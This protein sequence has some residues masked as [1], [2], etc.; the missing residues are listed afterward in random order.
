MGGVQTVELLVLQERRHRRMV[1]LLQLPFAGRGEGNPG[2]GE[3]LDDVVR[4]IRA[5][6]CTRPEG[7]G[8]LI[9]QLHH[10]ARLQPARIALAQQPVEQRAVH[11]RPPGHPGPPHLR[12]DQHARGLRGQQ[13]PH[14]V[15]VFGLLRTRHLAACRPPA[16]PSARPCRAAAAPDPART[17]TAGSRPYGRA[18]PR[19]RAGRAAAPRR[20]PA[21]AAGPTGPPHG[22]SAAPPRPLRHSSARPAPPPP[23]AAGRSPRWTAT[24]TARPR[25]GSAPPPRATAPA[26]PAR[27]AA[28]PGR[29][30]RDEHPR[31]P[32]PPPPISCP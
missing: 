26:P 32:S 29:A 10:P 24:P 1:D 9:G 6:P 3:G 30:G 21:N 25:D 7:P 4:Q 13:Q 27:R 18:R 2:A 17:A 19:G 16:V 15:R 5:H 23:A 8:H 20:R 22:R 11:I 12:G 28:R 31:R 14:P